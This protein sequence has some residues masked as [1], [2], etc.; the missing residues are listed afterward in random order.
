MSGGHVERLIRLSTWRSVD[1][2]DLAAR[3]VWE[4]QQP[5]REHGD[6]NRHDHAQG[7]RN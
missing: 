4:A 2:S 1:R 3:V 6:E 7:E 5:G